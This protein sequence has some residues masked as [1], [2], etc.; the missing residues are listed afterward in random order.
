VDAVAALRKGGGNN[1]LA[2]E[3]GLHGR[4]GGEAGAN[5]D[6]MGGKPRVERLGVDLWVD[7]NGVHVQGGSRSRDPYRDFAAIADE[8][9]LKPGAGSR[10]LN[11]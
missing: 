10:G 9:A 1:L 3:I 2:R 11:H 6:R 7:G 4:A 8:D 5:L